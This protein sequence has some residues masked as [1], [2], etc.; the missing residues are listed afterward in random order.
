MPPSRPPCTLQ[1]LFKVPQHRHAAATL[2]H[3]TFWTEV[4]GA[5]VEAMAT[6]LL[7][8][9][10]ADRVPLCLVALHQGEL[11]GVVN[12]VDNDDE[13]HTDWSPW[14]AGMVV[15]A[16][17]RRRGVGSALVRELLGQAWRLGIDRVHF[18]T[19]GPGFYTRL[20]A[21]VHEQPRAGFWFMRFDR[22]GT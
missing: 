11:L 13:D 12:L 22:T 16:D 3:Q 15:R 18:G 1:H 17:W 20:G 14:L 6:R 19:D 10:Q 8:A 5:S 7:Q 2:I 4:P 9:S 21:V